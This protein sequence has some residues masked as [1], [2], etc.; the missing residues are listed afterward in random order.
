MK[1]KRKKHCDKYLSFYQNNFNIHGPYQILVDLTLCQSA[2][3]NRVQ[4]KEQLSKYLSANYKLFNTKCVLE[5]GEQLGSRLHGALLVAKTFETRHCGH[6]SAI[7]ADQCIRSFFSK[8][9][10]DGL[11]VASQDPEL[12]QELRRLSGVPLL[13]VNHNVIVLEKPSTSS[14]RTSEKDNKKKLLTDY[15]KDVLKV[16]KK[17]DKPEFKGIRKRK[18]PKGPNPLSV[19]KKKTSEEGGQSS[20]NKEEQGN[21]RS[22]AKRKR[23][24]NAKDQTI[25]TNA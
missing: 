9:N 15:E 2:L 10:P 5:E 20:V 23:K 19:K 17:T 12:R 21:T 14:Q 11:F 22:R 13:H 24:T 18:G 25:L 3:Q 8:G 1:I 16:L 4:I 6:T 7:P